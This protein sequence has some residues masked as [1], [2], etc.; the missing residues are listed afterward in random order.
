MM[1]GEFCVQTVEDPLALSRMGIFPS[2]VFLRQ[3][4]PLALRRSGTFNTLRH[5][6]PRMFHGPKGH[7][8]PGN[9]W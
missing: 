6:R 1:E 3:V 4:R 2:T 8:I 5:A 9:Q 7:N